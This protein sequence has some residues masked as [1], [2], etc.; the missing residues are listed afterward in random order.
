MKK[1][2]FLIML[3]SI[4]IEITPVVSLI[5]F[6]ALIFMSTKAQIAVLILSILGALY[7]WIL[8]EWEDAKEKINQ[9]ERKKELEEK[10]NKEG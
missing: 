3:K 5:A 6:I 7:F 10:L 4:A 2:Q 9:I 8:Y 1:L